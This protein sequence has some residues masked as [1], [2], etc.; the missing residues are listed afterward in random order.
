MP[1]SIKT[2]VPLSLSLSLSLCLSLSVSLSLCLSVS[3]CLSLS[4]SHPKALCEML[5]CWSVPRADAAVCAEWG[6]VCD[7]FDPPL[8]T[9]HGNGSKHKAVWKEIQKLPESLLRGDYTLK[10]AWLR[11]EM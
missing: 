9:I 10:N 1:D 7:R 5:R 2:K 4:L 3:L 11:G 8:P 6:P